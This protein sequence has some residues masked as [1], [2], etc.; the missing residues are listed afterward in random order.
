ML[1]LLL[2]LLLLHMMTSLLQVSTSTGSFIFCKGSYERVRGRLATGACPRDYDETCEK[3]AR[4]GSYVLALAY[5]ELPPSM[6]MRDLLGMSRKDV[7][8]DLTLVGC[9]TFDNFVKVN[10]CYGCLCCGDCDGD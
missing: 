10:R 8:C 3:M 7:E 1:L 9:M 6:R 5:K 4:N 2:L